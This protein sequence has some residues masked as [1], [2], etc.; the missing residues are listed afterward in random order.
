MTNNEMQYEGALRHVYENGIE[1]SDRTG[2]GTKRVF[3]LQYRYD[4]SKAFPLIT[5][6][7]VHFKS[8]VGEL[9]WLLSGSTNVNDL[10]ELG[11]TIWD[12]W[13]RPYSLNRSVTFVDRVGPFKR[14]SYAGSFDWMKQHKTDPNTPERTLMEAWKRMMDRCYNPG[15]DN[16]AYYGGKGVSV[17]KR[18]HDPKSFIEDAQKLPHY[19]YKAR[20]PEGFD[21]DKDYYGSNQYNPES[22]VWIPGDENRMYMS[23][24]KPVRVTNTAGESQDFI[25]I[26]QAAEFLKI[27]P[28]S[29][30]RFVKQDRPYAFKGSN[31]TFVG[32]EFNNVEIEGKLARLE[33]I[34]DGDLGPVYGQQWRNQNG[35]DQIK[36]VVDEIRRNPDS[37]RLI[38]SAWNPADLPN[39]ALA[40]CHT[41]FQFY[42]QN[43]KLSCQLYQRS[44]DMFLGVPF[45]IASY[46]L[47]THMIAAVCGLE[48]GDFV[49]TI[50][51]AHIYS[52]HYDQVAEQLSR[53]P[54]D[55]PQ[56]KLTDTNLNAYPWEFK[57]EDVELVG[58]KPHPAIKADVAV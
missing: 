24:V 34:P 19:W 29:L 33:L 36:W 57:P 5:S 49:H 10:H 22:C 17:C 7:K 11:V 35:I 4:L 54:R 32:W 39:M 12:E 9:I 26:G 45:N 2:V 51:D 58:Y 41:M 15:A 50:G 52:N 56:I 28:S 42:V 44:A 47:L 14:E 18:W 3:G 1:S 6:K 23:T 16:Y 46:A 31:K 40:P 20:N 43:G 48:V 38:V 27:A 25:T 53:A 30:H 8:V 13:R 37:R 21:L 55:L